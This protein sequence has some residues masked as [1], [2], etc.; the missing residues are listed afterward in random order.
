MDCSR[1]GTVNRAEARACRHCGSPLAVASWSPPVESN[2]ARLTPG[3][4]SSPARDSS[5]G[6]GDLARL[7]RHPLQDAAAVYASLGPKRAAVVGLCCAIASLVAAGLGVWLG[8]KRSGALSYLSL[9]PDFDISLGTWTKFL[10]VSL[11]PF[12]SLVVSMMAARLLFRGSGR[13][14][15]DVFVAGAAVLPFGALILL[16]GLLGVG[17]LE[18]IAALAV[19]ALCWTVL[20]L[21]VGCTRV[22]HMSADA[23][24]LAVPTMILLCGWLT[25]VLFAMLM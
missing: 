23:A 9:M 22:A 18:V 7:L 24:G 17:N 12:L 13:L 6:S 10:A 20:I 8:L 4:G 11:I 15:G 14:E 1:C 25:K 5:E 21:F 2:A 19:F 16:A 3:Y